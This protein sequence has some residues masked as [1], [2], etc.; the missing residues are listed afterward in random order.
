MRQQVDRLRQKAGSSVIVLGWREDEGKVPLLVAVTHDL[1]AR[2]I[3]AGVLIKAV[4]VV[5]GGKG[6]GK[7]E[8]AQAG[9]KDPAKLPE[10]LALARQTVQERLSA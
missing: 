9:G 7:P 6:G 5:V 3:K 10:A 2:G 4:A 8:L 1:V